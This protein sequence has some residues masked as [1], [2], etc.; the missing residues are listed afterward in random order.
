MTLKSPPL[1][2]PL[3]IDI[4]GTTL[5]ETDRARLGHPLVGGVILFE[6]NYVDR[7]QLGDLIRDLHALRAPQLLIAVDHEGGRIQRWRD[8]F[9][10]LPPASDIG[11]CYDRDPGAGLELAYSVG[12]VS[13]CEMAAVGV[14]IVFAP[15]V[16]L[17]FGLSSVIGDRA[18]HREAEVVAALARAVADGLRDAG[19]ATVAKHFPG[20]GG[21]IPD[22]HLENAVDERDA[23]ALF[24][25]DLAPYRDLLPRG[26]DGVMTAH[27]RYPAVDSQ[28]A[29]Y[30]SF[31]IR[32]ILRQR[33]QFDGLVFSDDLTMAGAGDAP[34]PTRVADALRTG[35]D[36][37]LVCNHPGGV[38][39]LLARSALLDPRRRAARRHRWREGIEAGRKVTRED[40]EYDTAR[41]IVTSQ[42]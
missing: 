14:D 34:L 25:Q 38:S 6:R 26:V 2:G 5:G 33:F 30:S 23:A 1:L 15:V 32:E 24:S 36:M 42:D 19:I 31:W 3:M 28:T 35:I 10:A 9:T 13:G 39:E 22:T 12:V 27:I 7:Q 21:V 41:R 29:T 17:D 40:P 18:L 16:D 20:H 8:G 11:R 4:A 37:V